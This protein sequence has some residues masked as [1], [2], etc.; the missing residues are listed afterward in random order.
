MVINHGKKSVIFMAKKVVTLINIQKI[1]NQ[2]QNKFEDETKNFA[3][4]IANTMH[5]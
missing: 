1:R 5:F 2:R 4:I 3:E